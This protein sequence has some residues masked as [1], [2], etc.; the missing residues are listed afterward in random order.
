MKNALRLMRNSDL[1]RVCTL[2]ADANKFANKETIMMWTAES[3]SK[4]PNYHFVIEQEHKIIAAASVTLP[5]LEAAE[6]ED[7][8]VDKSLRGKGIGSRL[9]ICI[10]DKLKS[11]GVK[12][13]KLWVHHL[14]N[15]AVGFYKKHGFTVT[16]TGVTKGIK[17]VPDNEK[18]TYLEIKL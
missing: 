4:Y 1:S 6:L 10:L 7:I 16:G 9:I 17:Y 15:D 12:R 2:Y 5:A 8:A 11:N 18:I 14:S 3:L 13:V